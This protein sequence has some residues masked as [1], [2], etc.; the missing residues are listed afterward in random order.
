MWFIDINTYKGDDVQTTKNRENFF[1]IGWY[2]K[3]GEQDI[4]S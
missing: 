3:P 2:Y 4:F 1:I